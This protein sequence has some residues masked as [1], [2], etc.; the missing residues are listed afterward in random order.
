LRWIKA[1]AA[2]VPLNPGIDIRVFTDMGVVA[3]V[4]ALAHL[5]RGQRA[6]VVEL[7]AHGPSAEQLPARLRELGFIEGEDVEVLTAAPGG[8]PL[9]VRVGVTTFALRAAEAECVL[10]Q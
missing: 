10:V 8:G 6:A 9:A 4:L 1:A 7:R 3:A 5:P 2:P